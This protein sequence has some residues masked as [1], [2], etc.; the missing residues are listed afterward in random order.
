MVPLF[1]LDVEIQVKVKRSGNRS[2]SLGPTNRGLLV[3]CCIL[4]NINWRFSMFV[5]GHT[6]RVFF[7]SLMICELGAVCYV[8]LYLINE[9][10][11]RAC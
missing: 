7:G 9:Y 6:R 11:C 10:V 3:G 5:L 4:G 8:I 1:D 2:V